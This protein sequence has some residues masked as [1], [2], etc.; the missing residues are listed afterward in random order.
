MTPAQFER[1]NIVMKSAW[2][3]VVAWLWRII[4]VHALLDMLLL[5]IFCDKLWDFLKAMQYACF[6]VL[7]IIICG[8]EVHLAESQNFVFKTLVT[9]GG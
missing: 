2:F 5:S 8:T 6:V 7:L 4:N 9:N 1:Q 3:F